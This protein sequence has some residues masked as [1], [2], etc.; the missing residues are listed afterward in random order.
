[1]EQKASRR[2]D[3]APGI[4]AFASFNGEDGVTLDCRT[5]MSG[6]SW[7]LSIKKINEFLISKLNKGR[8]ITF[9]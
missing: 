3:L 9:T 6:R 5:F 8:N 4:I 2:I 7:D 1:M